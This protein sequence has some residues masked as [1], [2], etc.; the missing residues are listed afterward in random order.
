[1]ID[2]MSITS[3]NEAAFQAGAIKE[4]ARW[5]AFTRAAKRYGISGLGALSI[6]GAHFIAAIV[7]LRMLPPAEF[8]LVSFLFVVTPPLLS[9]TM[10]LLY[11]PLVTTMYRDRA[12]ARAELATHLK[13]NLCVAVL[14]TVFLGALMFSCGAG[15]ERATLFGVYGGLMSLRQFARCYMYVE[16][17]PFV[18]AASDVTYSGLLLAGLALLFFTHGYHEP[19]IA[20]VLAGAAA[21]AILP[22]GREYLVRQFTSGIFGWAREYS[23]FW[24][25]T[26]RWSLLGVVATEITANAH[27]YLVTL[28][29]GSHA[30]AL[31]AAGALFMRPVSLVLTAL[32]ELERPA[33][34]RG[35]IARDLKAAFRPVKIFRLLISASWLVTMAAT[36][37]V[38]LWF[39]SIVLKS[40]YPVDEVAI[41]VAFWAAIMLVRVIRTPDGVLMQAATE[42][43]ALAWASVGSAVVSLILTL[44]LLIFFG[45]IASLAG[46]L[47]GEIVMMIRIRMLIA[48]WK[49]RYA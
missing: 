31:L 34:A 43:R 32:P 21:T 5:Q 30:F 42:F 24:R 14:V 15:L 3:V 23:V 36:A 13:A 9:V 47:A 2:E 33:M 37:A 10:S 16:N 19:Y 8:G 17:R 22:F 20:I 48:N 45:P 38:L 39:P 25:E 12:Q 35:I 26:S 1:M 27:A 6:A 41:V 46:I 49:K 4:P 11:A 28:I 29:S 7:F 40:H 18:V 44:A